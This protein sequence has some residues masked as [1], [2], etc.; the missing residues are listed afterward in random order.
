M[1]IFEQCLELKNDKTALFSISDFRE[2]MLDCK[3]STLLE[4][5]SADQ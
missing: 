5:K 4:I 2:K 3:F 1:Q